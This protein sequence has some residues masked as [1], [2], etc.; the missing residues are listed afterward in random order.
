MEYE[1]PDEDVLFD[2]S[3]NPSQKPRPRQAARNQPPPHPGDY[4][5]ERKRRQK[6]E[7]IPEEEEYV[8]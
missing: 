2:D 3:A 7:L 6:A 4:L 8:V 5:V 1:M